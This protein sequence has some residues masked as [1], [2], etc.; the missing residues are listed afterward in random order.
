MTSER[1]V[2]NARGEQTFGCVERPEVSREMR[3]SLATCL[4]D[5]AKHDDSFGCVEVL[6]SAL[7]GK[8]LAPA[9]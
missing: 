5:K 7:C 6:M 4:A 1:I 2:Q 8:S 3:R 9:F